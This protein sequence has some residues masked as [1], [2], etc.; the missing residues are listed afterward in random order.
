MATDEQRWIERLRRRDE[1][2]FNELVRRHQEPIFR[3]LS[4]MLGDAAEAE[5]VAQEVFVSVFK[6]IDSFRGDAALSTWLYRV[7]VN[8]GKNRIKYLARRARDAQRP[9]DE[10]TEGQ[11]ASM[12]VMGS[13]PA[14]PD[15]VAEALQ[16]E[17]HVQRALSCLEEEQRVLVVLRDVENLSYD[18]IVGVTGLPIGTVKS[19][20]HRAR[21]ALHKAFR[22]LSEEP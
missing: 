16:A 6:S 3:L 22:A 1:G 18:E 14:S 13:R 9:L 4:S 10:R 12:G 11:Q 2:A 17:G 19:R 5:D 20:L 21:L 8:H 7:A 15:Q